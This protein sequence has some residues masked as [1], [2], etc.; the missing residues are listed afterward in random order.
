[1]EQTH[2][3]AMTRSLAGF[4][5]SIGTDGTITAQG[6]ILEVLGADKTVSEELKQ[7]QKAIQKAGEEV[8]KPNAPSSDGKLIVAEEIE[9]G[10]I[11]WQ[12]CT[13]YHDHR[14]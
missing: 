11:S 9:E 6:T 2:N 3:V 4:V 8:D 1:M 14:N 10:H 7:D 5:V 12:S 13:L